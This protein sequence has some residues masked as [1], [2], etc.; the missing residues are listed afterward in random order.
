MRLPTI[1]FCLFVLV[2]ACGRTGPE[3]VVVPAAPCGSGSDAATA[4]DV[5]TAPDVPTIVD[6]PA[7]VGEMPWWMRVSYYDTGTETWIIATGLDTSG[8]REIVEM[9][10]VPMQWHCRSGELGGCIVTRHY[11]RDGRFE[12]MVTTTGGFRPAVGQTCQDLVGTRLHVFNSSMG[13]PARAS[14]PVA[15]QG[16]LTSDGFCRFTIRRDAPESSAPNYQD[17]LN[18]RPVPWF[19]IVRSTEAMASMAL[20]WE[21]GRFCNV[22]QGPRMFVGRDNL[23]HHLVCHGSLANRSVRVQFGAPGGGGRVSP[24]ELNR[25][26]FPQGSVLV[27]TDAMGGLIGRELRPRS[28]TADPEGWCTYDLVR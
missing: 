9:S 24:C 16:V 18:G 10:P 21:D 6:V 12:F 25:S 20:W 4:A 1:V 11:D 2:S 22:D 8:T 27:A 3:D 5:T 23:Y 17:F 7:D 26:G 13:R 15:V 19:L 28:A 14:F